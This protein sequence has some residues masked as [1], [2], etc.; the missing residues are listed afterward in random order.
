MAR[1]PPRLI[2]RRVAEDRKEG[3]RSGV[4]HVRGGA[5]WCARVGVDRRAEGDVKRRLVAAALHATHC[6]EP[7]VEDQ[8][9]KGRGTDRRRND[10]DSWLR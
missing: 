7:V 4:G 1:G 5:G 3:C 9:R 8:P 2:A 6:E 10:G